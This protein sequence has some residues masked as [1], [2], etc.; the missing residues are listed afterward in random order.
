MAIPKPFAECRHFY[1][2]KALR[3]LDEISADFLAIEKGP[4][5]CWMDC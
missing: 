2:P 4:R 3:T 1:K 5:G